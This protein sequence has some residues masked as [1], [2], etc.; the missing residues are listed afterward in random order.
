MQALLNVIAKGGLKSS[1]L[2]VGPLNVYI[3]LISTFLYGLH[4]FGGLVHIDHSSLHT[5]PF[6][7]HT[8]T[9]PS[10]MISFVLSRGH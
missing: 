8:L 5:L 9:C 2:Y 4:T 7:E 6:L 1:L 3:A 10:M